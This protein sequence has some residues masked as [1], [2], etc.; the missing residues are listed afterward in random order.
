LKESGEIAALTVLTC[1]GEHRRIFAF[2]NYVQK[3]L[4]FVQNPPALVQKAEKTGRFICV[5]GKYVVTLP[6]QTHLKFNEK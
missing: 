3:T 6:G 2:C 4:Y 5:F 1:F